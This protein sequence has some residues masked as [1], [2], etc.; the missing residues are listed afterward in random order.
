MKPLFLSEKIGYVGVH[1]VRL[2]EGKGEFLREVGDEEPGKSKRRWDGGRRCYSVPEEVGG[3]LR[4]SQAKEFV[5]FFFYFVFIILLLFF[6]N[7]IFFF[8][9]F[10]FLFLF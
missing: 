7:L 9:F 3:C 6:F 2:E 8:N 5:F 1:W 4:D 10:F